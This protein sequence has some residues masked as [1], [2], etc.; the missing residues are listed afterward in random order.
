MTLIDLPDEARIEEAMMTILFCFAFYSP[1][2]STAEEV[3]LVCW[4]NAGRKEDCRAKE[5]TIEEQKNNEV[6]LENGEILINFTL[7]SS[8]IKNNKQHNE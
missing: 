3:H 8:M 6:V 2:A 4:D 1:A 7:Y 5:R